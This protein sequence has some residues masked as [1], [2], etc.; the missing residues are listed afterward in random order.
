MSAPARSA[1]D[2]TTSLPAALSPVATT[3]QDGRDF[4]AGGPDGSEKADSAIG[5]WVAAMMAVCRGDRSAANVVWNL[6]GSIANSVAVSWPW[7][8]GYRNGTS[9]VLRTL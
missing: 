3:A 1:M 2:R 8:V 4:H 6:A 5:R 9:A 7:P